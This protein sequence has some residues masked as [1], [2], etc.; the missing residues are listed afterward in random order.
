M[1]LREKIASLKQLAQNLRELANS[2]NVKQASETGQELNNLETIY[3][4]VQLQNYL[5]VLGDHNGY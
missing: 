2:P 3:Y 4:Q 1:E 5:S